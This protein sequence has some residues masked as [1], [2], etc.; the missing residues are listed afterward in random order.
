[1]DIFEFIRSW[2]LD[3]NPTTPRTFKKREVDL[4]LE[5]IEAL[6]TSPAEPKIGSLNPGI[7][8]G[9]D[10]FSSQPQRRLDSLSVPILLSKRV[11]LP[12]PVF[13]AIAPSAASVW[14]KMPDSGS[15]YFTNAPVI[16]TGWK[17]VAQI[18]ASQRKDAL[19]TIFSVAIPRLLKLEQLV[20]CGAIG[21]YSWERLVEDDLPKFQETAMTLKESGLVDKVGT[22]YPQHDYSLGTRLSGIRITIQDDHPVT[23]AKAGTPLWIS[24]KMPILV[25]GLLNALTSDRLASRFEPSLPGD[26]I[27]YDFVRSNGKSYTDKPSQDNFLQL[28]ALDAAV[29]EDV[30]AIRKD[31]ELLD[32]FREMLA[33]LSIAESS[34]AAE[35]IR[36]GLKDLAKE[37]NADKALLKRTGS[38]TLNFL[39]AILGGTLVGGYTGNLAS[40]ALTTAMSAG[41]PYLKDLAVTA[42]GG[43]ARE[44]KLRYEVVTRILHRF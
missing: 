16:H 39:L 14:E 19:R 27:V 43:Q 36:G 33:E 30:V 20:Q 32:R 35:A 37:L 34:L 7:R 5:D 22:A 18:P 41:I 21:F 11:W 15:T 23:G 13:S 17:H 25:Y 10:L 24:E 3:K 4:L 42:F 28:P 29:W 31:S 38:S 9:L 40:G 26:R 8:D 2:N 44:T 1:M 6:Y 12:D